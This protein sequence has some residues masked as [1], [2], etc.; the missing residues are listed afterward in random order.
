[1]SLKLEP[2]AEFARPDCLALMSQGLQC[3][4]MHFHTRFSDSFT[5]VGSALKLAKARGTGLA[6][7]DHNLIQ[8]VEEAVSMK[9]D[10]M[11]IPGI[12]VSTWDGPHVLVYFYDASSL[13]SYWERCIRPNM[14]KSPWLAISKGTEWLLDSL[15]GECCLV[16]AAHPMGYL[17]ACKGLQKCIDKGRLADTVARRFDAYEV[18]CSGMSRGEN[19]GALKAA[20]RYRLGFTGGT[21]GHL[22]WE[23]GNVVTISES[24]D[25]EGFLKGVIE[26]R[27]RVIGMEKSSP[28]KVAMG[29][30]V[31]ARFMRYLPSSLMAHYRQ[32]IGPQSQRWH[33]SK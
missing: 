32:D 33:R 24:Q 23:L 13:R 27:N 6:I 12:E 7:T 1:M 25:V 4:D 19:I 14:S 30:A 29:T 3:A 2:G 16:S 11:V 28:T 8:G 15:E 20:E 26:K 5:D 22:L 18:I 17:M 31:T 10:V 9:P 21:D